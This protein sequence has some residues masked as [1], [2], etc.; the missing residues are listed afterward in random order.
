MAKWN[1]FFL[2]RMGTDDQD[3][4]YAVCESVATWHMWCKEIPFKTGEKVKEPA[5]RS[6]PDEDGDDEFIPTE[7]LRMEAYSMKVQFGCKAKDDTTN[8]VSAA[9]LVRQYTGNFLTYL[10][11]GMMK[12]YSSYTDVGR[13][14]VRL[15]SYD[16]GTF[17]ETDGEA[18]LFFDVTFKVNDPTTQIT[19]TTS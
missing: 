15:E 5:K 9:T 13:Q 14:N 4:P 8:H 12:M 2:Q 7:G 10:K 17:K 19:L 16:E 6:W 3:Q 11:T 18:F 1:N